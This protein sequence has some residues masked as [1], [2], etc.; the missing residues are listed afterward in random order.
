MNEY[1]LMKSAVF[2]GIMRRRV[3]IVY[4]RLGQRIGPILTIT[5]RRTVIP[6]NTAD[7]I[8]IAAEA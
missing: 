2:W 7:F 5:T 4:R 3:V 6:Q 8:N 1:N